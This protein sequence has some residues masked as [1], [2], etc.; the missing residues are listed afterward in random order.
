MFGGKA[1]TVTARDI[2]R[3][4][5]PREGDD[6]RY[7][8]RRALLDRAANGLPARCCESFTCPAEIDTDGW[9]NIGELAARVQGRIAADEAEPY[10]EH[11]R[12]CCDE[13]F[14][15][16]AEQFARCESPIE[17]S[18]LCAIYDCLAWSVVREELEIIAQHPLPHGYRADIWIRS[19][20]SDKRWD[21]ECDGREF[22]DQ[23]RDQIRDAALRVAGIRV[24]RFAGVEIRR[25]R[26]GLA[27]RALLAVNH[28]GAIMEAG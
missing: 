13:R 18:L 22:H 27:S 19:V 2:A 24:L 1:L 25:N 12:L 21:V 5:A 4:G 6:E 16:F 14:P 9:V 28:I 8:R 15:M 3:Q 7:D 11:G 26:R 23:A 17:V 10:W 20:A